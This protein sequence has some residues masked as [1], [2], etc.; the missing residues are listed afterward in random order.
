M[1]FFPRGP[2]DPAGPWPIWFIPT[3][4]WLLLIL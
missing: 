2:D 3:L 4:L 1:P